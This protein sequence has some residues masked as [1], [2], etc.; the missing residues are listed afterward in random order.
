MKFSLYLFQ[1]HL[2]QHP[3][4]FHIQP[5]YHLKVLALFF[6]D[7]AL[8]TVIKSKKSKRAS[9]SLN[10]DKVISVSVTTKTISVLKV[11]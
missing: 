6:L 11:V 7:L 2:F 1:N 9:F 8:Q 4:R 10:T 3:G 5:W